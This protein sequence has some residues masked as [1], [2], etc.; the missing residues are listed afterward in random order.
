[1]D[2]FA[3]EFFLEE[4]AIENS[5]QHALTIKK[6]KQLIESKESDEYTRRIKFARY[7]IRPSKT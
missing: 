3:D 5:L 4:L 1:M 6:E 7:Q 2:V